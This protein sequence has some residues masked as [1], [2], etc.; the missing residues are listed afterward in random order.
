MTVWFAS[1]RDAKWLIE[2]GHKTLDP[3]LFSDWVTRLVGDGM[4]EEDAR[5]FVRYEM[6]KELENE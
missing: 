4:N 6:V 2:N 1:V 5:C 3:V